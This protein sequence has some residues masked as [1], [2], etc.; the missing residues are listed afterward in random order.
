M[1]ATVKRTTWQQ[2][3]CDIRPLFKDL[4]NVDRSFGAEHCAMSA[5][6]GQRALPSVI[7]ATLWG[8]GYTTIDGCAFDR[9][10]NFW[11]SELFYP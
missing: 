6:V 11:A 1:T 9:Q 10:G 8:T 5:T 2:P 4:R 7:A 3:D